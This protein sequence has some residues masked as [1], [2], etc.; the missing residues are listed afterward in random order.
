MK[1]PVRGKG[2]EQV[3]FKQGIYLIV[4][5]IIGS[6]LILPIGAKAKQDLWIAALLALVFALPMVVV[7]GRILSLNAGM[8]LLEI[9]TRLFGT[10]IGKAIIL[11]YAFYAFT[12]SGLVL[13]NFGE[14]I[15][16][17]AIPETPKLVIMFFLILLAIWAVKEGIEVIARMAEIYFPWI[18]ISA[19]VTFLLLSPKFEIQRFYPIL[20]QNHQKIFQAAIDLFS[21]PL[22][23]M[24]LFLL[25]LPSSK[26]AS[27]VKQYMLGLLLGFFAV[28]TSITTVMV[29][30]GSEQYGAHYFPGFLAVQKI[31]IGD[32]LQRLE[33]VIFLI[34]LFAGFI[35]ICVC[36]LGASR[37]ICHVFGFAD[38]RFLVTPVGFLSLLFALNIYSSTKQ[39]ARWADAIYPYY[40]FPFQ[41]LLPLLIW[42]V[43]EIKARAEGKKGAPAKKDEG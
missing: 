10:I 18:I 6:S 28:F 12:L 30:V 8:D 13:I 24:V 19:I 7:Y 5:F 9:A 36:L 11:V 29:V 31:S 1:S 40:A 43:A 16:V 26:Q 14:F 2:K 37:G 17:V 39:M 21:F 25:L 38:Y 35:K 32:F 41:V 20:Y 42:I 27:V 34:T 33:V 4:L 22:A 15:S 3:S 23:E